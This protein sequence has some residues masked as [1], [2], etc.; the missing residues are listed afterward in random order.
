MVA[1][2][3]HHETE[4][5]KRVAD[6]YAY[7]A[8]WP[9]GGPTPQ[10]F[11]ATLNTLLDSHERALE[12]EDKT[13]EADNNPF[14]KKTD[15]HIAATSAEAKEIIATAISGIARARALIH[16]A[17]QAYDDAPAGKLSDESVD[18]LQ[19]RLQSASDALDGTREAL[20]APFE[21]L[22]AMHPNLV[23]DVVDKA[24]RRLAMP[25][26]LGPLYA[27]QIKTVETDKEAEFARRFVSE[28][29]YARVDLGKDSTLI[30]WFTAPVKLPA[31]WK[32]SKAKL[33]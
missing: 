18:A 17:L 1:T 32:A 7:G 31:P 8:P 25:V 3:K 2:F 23:W 22:L 9:T 6:H 4:A 5:I 20:E 30:V 26:P 14:D 28:F 12:L 27:Y 10:E 11:G 19:S 33:A 15:V 16:I 13:V 21:E 29:F 24:Q